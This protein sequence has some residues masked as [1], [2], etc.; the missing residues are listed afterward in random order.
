M[1]LQCR[2]ALL[3]LIASTF[4]CHD[5]FGP[6][7][8]PEDFVLDNINGRSLPT[9]FSPIPETPTIVSATLHLD[10]AGT[11]T[12]TERRHDMVYGDVTFTNSTGYRINGNSIEIGCFHTPPGPIVLVCGFSSTGTL[13][14]EVLSLPVSQGIIYTY[15]LSPKA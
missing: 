8:T 9:F 5:T 13:S 12:M 15:R 7:R 6:S 2:T 1:N 10:G 14:G 11:A 4:A 3:A